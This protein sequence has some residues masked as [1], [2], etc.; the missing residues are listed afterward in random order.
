MLTGVFL[1]CLVFGGVWLL[2]AAFL[3]DILGGGDADVGDHDFDAGGH[4]IDVGGHDVDAGGHDP[5]GDV[6]VSDAMHLW[7]FSPLILACFLATFGASGLIMIKLM[8]TRILDI[9][10]I[11]PA[12]GVG[13][14]VSGGL[15]Y[16]F[17]RL[18]SSLEGSSEARIAR[19]PGHSAQVITPIPE[20]KAGEVSFVARGTRLNWSARSADGRPIPKGAKVIIDEV[21]QNL[22]VV[23]LHPDEKMKQLG[24]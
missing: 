10:V 8:P 1:F 15:I 9:L 24:E 13:V 18:S 20:N 6:G 16:G 17:N 14:L 11:L 22:L 3:G 21:R 23:S 2:L 12:A 4:D 5:G 7:P 19:L